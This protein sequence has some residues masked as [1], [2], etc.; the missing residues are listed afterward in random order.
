[1]PDF[2]VPNESRVTINIPVLVFS[3]AVSLL[4]GNRVRAGAGAAD[5][6]GRM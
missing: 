5:V 1:M 3:L 6:E 2:Y 4:T